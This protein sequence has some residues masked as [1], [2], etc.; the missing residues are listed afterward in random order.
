VTLWSLSQ[1]ELRSGSDDFVDRAFDSVG[2]LL[3][4]RHAPVDRAS[5]FEAL[6]AGGY[7]AVQWMVARIWRRWFARY[8][9]TV[10]AREIELI[11]DIRRAGVLITGRFVLR[12]GQRRLPFGDRLMALPVSD[13]WS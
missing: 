1:G 4:S 10:L 2:Q 12:T 8:V 5:Y 6:C 3:T 7:P 11:A 9:E 13:L